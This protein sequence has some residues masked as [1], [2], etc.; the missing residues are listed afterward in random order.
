MPERFR[1]NHHRHVEQFEQSGNPNLQMDTNRTLTGLHSDG[2]EIP[3]EASLSQVEVSGKK[4]FTVI[5]RDISVRLQAE[6][7][8]KQLNRELSRQNEQ[9]QQFGFIT[10]HNIRGPV[11]SLLGLTN[12]FNH[13][14]LDDPD[15]AVIIHNIAATVNKLDGVIRDLNQILDYKRD[16]AQVKEMVSVEEVFNNVCITI[17]RWIEESNCDIETS[18]TSVPAVY[19][20]KSYM[21]SIF[22]NL[23][24]NAIK[25]R[26]IDRPL[27]VEVKS[28]REKDN[29]SIS[30]RDNGTGIDLHKYRH[31]LFGLY[32]RFHMQV[33]GKGLGLHLVKTQV[34]ALNGSIEVE[35][36]VDQG[37]TFLISLP[38]EKG[39]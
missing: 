34:E 3:L 23:L 12:L 2:R 7:Q 18:F 11:A 10:S 15:N 5:L 24:T 21:Q 37:T 6:K 8:E 17:S 19:A 31:H 16:I 9:L 27:K 32:K 26:S 28:F 33:D 30:F 38:D 29:I 4:Y 20:I 14:K 22:Y 25:F 1:P 39:Y 36:I 13:E 35:S